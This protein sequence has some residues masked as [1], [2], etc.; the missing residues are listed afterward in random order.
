MLMWDPKEEWVIGEGMYSVEGGDAE[1]VE[2]VQQEIGL[3]RGE[4][5]EIESDDSCD[6]DPKVAPPSLKEMIE[7]CW[8]LEENCMMVCSDGTLDFVRATCQY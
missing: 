2:I 5:E 7:M 8:T 6:D 1:I 3:A 4:I